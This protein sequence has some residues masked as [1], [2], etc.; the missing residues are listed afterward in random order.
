MKKTSK[1]LLLSLSAVLLVTAAV[2]GTM[3]YLTS[4]DTVTNTFTVGSVSITLDEKDVDNSTDGAERDQ[5]N[6]YKLVPGKTYEKDP[7]VHVAAESEDSYLFVKVE[8]GISDIEGTPTV[9]SQIG[10][11]GWNAVPNVDNVYVYG[12]ATSPTTVNGGTDVSVFDTF[13]IDG[14]V[15]NGTLGTYAD[16]NITVTAY[17]IQADGFDGKT[18]AE[19]WTAAEFS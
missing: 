5:E 9:A 7:I 14:T 16:K 8:N 13:T 18:A 3:A 19:I 15:D 10:D 2:L 17:A 12:S 11:K 4:Q 6:A 1:A